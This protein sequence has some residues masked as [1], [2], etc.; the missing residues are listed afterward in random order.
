MKLKVQLK[1]LKGLAVTDVA[2]E[3]G[4]VTLKEGCPKADLPDELKALAAGKLR[5][6]QDWNYDEHGADWVTK[7]P[8]CALP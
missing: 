6:N 8:D 2:K 3:E 4:I 5:R 7:Y 1:K